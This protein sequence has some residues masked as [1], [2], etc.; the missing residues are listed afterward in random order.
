MAIFA[1][2]PLTVWGDH[3]GWSGL[4]LFAIVGVLGGSAVGI[5]SYLLHHETATRLARRDENGDPVA[6]TDAESAWF[7]IFGLLPAAA[8]SK[9]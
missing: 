5:L 1:C 8:P 6:L 3:V 4:W 9:R 7:E 2:G